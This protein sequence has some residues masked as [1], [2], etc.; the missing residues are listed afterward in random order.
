MADK[1]R[2][3]RRTA[4]LFQDLGLAG[5]SYRNPSKRKQN[6]QNAVA[7]LEGILLTTGVLKS[8]VIEKTKDGKDYKVV[9]T[10]SARSDLL[11]E[12]TS[13]ETTFVST[14]PVVINDYSKRKDAAVL[15]AEELVQYFYKL[16]HGIDSHSP[17]SKE[18]SQALSLVSQHGLDKA[19]AVVDFARSEAL[20]TN[21][22]IQHFGAVLSYASRA[23]ATVSRGS[24]P[25]ATSPSLSPLEKQTPLPSK[26]RLSRGEARLQSLTPEQRQSRLEL[27]KAELLRSV[28]FLAERTR[29]GS[30]LEE[31]MVRSHLVRQLEH[32][33]MDLLS[34]KALELPASLAQILARQ[35]AENSE[36]TI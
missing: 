11:D 12:A 16:F 29:A 32:E 2:F 28:P 27:A 34:L 4:E 20:K 13:P 14:A 26:P 15:Q 19:R 9:F 8:A 30:K 22:N 7:E 10:K 3:E 18:T 23:L 1:N 5:A 33:V 21:F 36:T 6:L 17:Q 25:A 24:A 35:A 31:S